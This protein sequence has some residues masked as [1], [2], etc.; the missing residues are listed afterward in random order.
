MNSAASKH[1]YKPRYGGFFGGVS[2]IRPYHFRLVNGFSN[3]YFG[4]G[5]EDN[6]FSKRLVKKS[7]RGTQNDHELGR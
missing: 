7:I 2:S 5:G 6:D 3:I 4:W 1:H